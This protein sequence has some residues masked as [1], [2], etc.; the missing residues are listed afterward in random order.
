MQSDI[1][2]N[3]NIN[4]SSI[5]NDRTID[6]RFDSLEKT[7]NFQSFNPGNDEHFNRSSDSYLDCDEKKDEI[8]N[9][10]IKIYRYKFS[11]DFI[12]ELYKFSKIHQYDNREDFK[13]AWESW[14][15][16][17]SSIIFKESTRLAELGYNGD[18]LN[19]MFTS[20]RYYFRKKGTEKKEPHIRCAYVGIQKELL[21][22]MDNH[23]SLNYRESWYKPSTGFNEFCKE[24]MDLL[25]QEIELLIKFDIVACDEIKKK[26]KK[27]YKNRYF[28]IIKKK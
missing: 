17:N 3:I 23:I 9:N 28:M 12:D 18:V 14:I 11:N 19:K 27:T 13:E 6:R 1:N 4:N 10:S 21:N 22:A 5:T 2:N 15:E 26:I 8:S 16:I 24:N 7:A 25:Q 20:G